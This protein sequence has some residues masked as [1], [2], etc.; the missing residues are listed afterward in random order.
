[1][2]RPRA[3]AAVAARAAGPGAAASRSRRANPKSK[4]T[5]LSPPAP[6]T[7]ATR[8]RNRGASSSPSPSPSPSSPGYVSFVSSPSSASPEPEP[9]SRSSKPRAKPAARSPPLA[10]PLPASPLSAAT[11]AAAAA[12]S[13]ISSVGDLRCAAASQMESL[14][15]RLDGLHS[16]A[17]T[18]LDASFSHASKRFKTQNQACQQLT[19]AVDKEYK[20]M[21]DSIK[22]TAEK[23]K[24][25]YK[26]SM[27]ETRSSTSHVSKVA[28]P[29]ITKSVEKA[30]DGLRR[31]YNISMPV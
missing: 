13:S 22:E 17:H 26:L 5:F 4:P 9:K 16:R 12:T 1:M 15:R 23:I 27:A 31:R 7:A 20:N 6:A 11:P 29:E 2:G 30:I 10:S 19:D 8:K 21:A 14:R 25:K 28:I 24:A 18:D 3:T